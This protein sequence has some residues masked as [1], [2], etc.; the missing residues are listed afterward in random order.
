[1]A[2]L[3]ATSLTFQPSLN[4]ST[5]ISQGCYKTSPFGAVCVGWNRRSF[6]SLRSSRFRICAVQAQPETL[7]K[8]CDIVRKQLALPKESELTPDTKFSDLGADSLDTVEI[9]M[10]LEEEFNINVEEDGSQN[11]STVQEA[12][13]LIEKLV[14]E[15]KVDQNKATEAA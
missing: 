3:S 10:T 8:V 4:F 7:Q 9:V 1:M 12:A 5:A 13:D 14:Q 6:P 15:K 2:S 11:I